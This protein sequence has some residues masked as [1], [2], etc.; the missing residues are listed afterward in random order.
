MPSAPLTTS[1]SA[2]TLGSTL[3][4]MPARCAT[5]RAERA[6]VPPVCANASS[7]SAETSKPMTSK[8]AWSRFAD[9]AEPMIPRPSM[10][11][12]GFIAFSIESPHLRYMMTEGIQVLSGG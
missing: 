9:I 5:S 6:G 3:M 1:S 8:P 7:L 2:A 12:L 11:T 10:P 4:M